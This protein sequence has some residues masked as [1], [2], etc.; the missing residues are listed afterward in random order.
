MMEYLA[1]QAIVAVLEIRKVAVGRR[2]TPVAVLLQVASQKRAAFKFQVRGLTPL[3]SRNRDLNSLRQLN[4][5]NQ[6]DGF[7]CH[8]A[9]G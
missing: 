8:D 7:R 2:Q 3:A 6:L 4:D 5:L 1:N 9:A